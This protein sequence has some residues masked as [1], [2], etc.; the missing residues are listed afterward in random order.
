M[1]NL[2][3]KGAKRV[4]I[5]V[6]GGTLVLIG[7]ALLVLPGPGILV[8]AAGLAVLAVEFAWARAWLAKLRRKISD[9]SR[10]QRVRGR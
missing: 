4:V 3:H 5:G 2:A 10:N 8:L 1:T 7:I 9:V 6:I